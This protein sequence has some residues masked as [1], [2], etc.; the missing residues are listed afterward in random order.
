MYIRY[1]IVSL[2]CC[3]LGHSLQANDTVFVNIRHC[4][5]IILPFQRK[6]S[7]KVELINTS[8]SL[9]YLLY[10]INYL[11]VTIYPDSLQDYKK[12]TYG[13]DISIKNEDG[14]FADPF[15]R[16]SFPRPKKILHHKF[17]KFKKSITPIYNVYDFSRII[18]FVLKPKQTVVNKYR[19]NIKNVK[20]KVGWNNVRVLYKS[21]YYRFDLIKEK[22]KEDEQKYNAK[23][24]FGITGSEY[25]RFYFWNFINVHYYNKH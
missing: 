5:K 12:Q 9:T 11:G 2:L 16:E 8:D 13:L 22:F 17:R 1:Y 3:L 18:P 19:V 20:I 14:E 4:S 21:G 24:F 25:K 23:V 7:I 15:F 10:N 6:I